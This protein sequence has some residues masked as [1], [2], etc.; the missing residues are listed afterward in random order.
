MELSLQV[1]YIQTNGNELQ[2]QESTKQAHK[3]KTCS[4]SLL[5]EP[6]FS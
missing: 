1:F 4:V 3:N 6:M 2:G 5:H